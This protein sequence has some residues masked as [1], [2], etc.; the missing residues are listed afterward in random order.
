[1]KSKIVRYN[2]KPIVAITLCLLIS[3]FLGVE[4]RMN[5]TISSTMLTY[6][7]QE[8]IV[9]GNGNILLLSLS[10]EQVAIYYP[11]IQ[12]QELQS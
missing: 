3:V 7:A 12:V 11:R 8:T 9:R 5:P 4:L 6:F 1:M 10:F 2:D